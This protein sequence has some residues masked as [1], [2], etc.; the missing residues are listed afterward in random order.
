MDLVDRARHRRALRRLDAEIQI[1]R[2]RRRSLR[3]GTLVT[4]LYRSRQLHRGCL[5]GKST[6]RKQQARTTG[7][8]A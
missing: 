4:R 2:L 3:Q 6:D 1:G 5:G 7:T 8:Q